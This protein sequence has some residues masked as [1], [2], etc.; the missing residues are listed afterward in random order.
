MAEAKCSAT[1]FSPAFRQ[2]AMVRMTIETFD[3]AL[4]DEYDSQHGEYDIE[5]HYKLIK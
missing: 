2:T 1:F 4:F 3:D 5:S